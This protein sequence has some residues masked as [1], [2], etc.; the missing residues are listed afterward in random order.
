MNNNKKNNNSEAGEL[1]VGRGGGNRG[2]ARGAGVKNSS[3]CPAVL[4]KE[5]LLKMSAFN[6]K[7]EILH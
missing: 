7:R 5:Q 2:D 3:S 6:L 1:L 4:P